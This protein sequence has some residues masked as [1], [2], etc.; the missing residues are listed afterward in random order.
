MFTFNFN[1][2]IYIYKYSKIL[3][4]ITIGFNVLL[5]HIRLSKYINYIGRYN[6]GQFMS[7]IIYKD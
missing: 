7:Y 6:R 3:L 4:L 1:F 5:V 2:Y